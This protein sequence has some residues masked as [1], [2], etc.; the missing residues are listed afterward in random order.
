MAT[1]LIIDQDKEHVA[2]VRHSL[3]EGGF[4]VI[5][6]ARGDAGLEIAL[7]HKPDLVL[8]EVKIPGLD[9]LEVCRRLRSADRESRIPV[10]IL[11]ELGAERHRVVGLELGA[12]DYVVKPFSPRELLARIKAVLRRVAA[13]EEPGDVRRSGDLVLDTGRREVTYLGNPIPLLV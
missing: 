9:G 7:R 1:V 3:T 4:D 11:S 8:L 12:D 2:L 6:A 13:A 10:I 5:A